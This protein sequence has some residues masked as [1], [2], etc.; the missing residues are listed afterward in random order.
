MGHAKGHT[1]SGKPRYCP[2]TRRWRLRLLLRTP[3]S[4]NPVISC[5]HACCHPGRHPRNVASTQSRDKQVRGNY[6]AAARV[7]SRNGACPVGKGETRPSCI[8][9]TFSRGPADLMRFAG[10]FRQGCSDAALVISARASDGRYSSVARVPSSS[11]ARRDCQKLSEIEAAIARA[12]LA[13][14]RR[15]LRFNCDVPVRIFGAPVLP[16]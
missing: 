10:P 1:L 14:R 6:R 9:G 12:H 4:S 15:R 3:G 16:P 11:R 13:R 5:C 2:A 7:S 8:A